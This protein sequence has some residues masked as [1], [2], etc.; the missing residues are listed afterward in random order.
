ME[1]II[2]LTLTTNMINESNS[3]IQLRIDES[4]SNIQLRID[5]SNRNDKVRFDELFRKIERKEKVYNQF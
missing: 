4:N 1:H 3:N 2:C 5:E